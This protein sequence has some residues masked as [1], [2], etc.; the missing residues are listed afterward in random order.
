MGLIVLVLAR[1]VYLAYFLTVAVL[2]FHISFVF[3]GYYHF[4]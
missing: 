1:I 4:L 2:A 3:L